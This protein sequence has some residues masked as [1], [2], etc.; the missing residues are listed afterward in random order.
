MANEPQFPPD[1]WLIELGKLSQSWATL[2]HWL[3]M[4]I[5]KLCSFSDGP[6]DPKFV[7]LIAHSSLPQRLDIFAALCHALLDEY[8]HLNGYQDVVKE[9]KAASTER[10]FFAHNMLTVDP[11]TEQVS[12]SVISARGKLRMEHVDVPL[13]RI[14]E[15]RAATFSAIKNFTGSFC[16]QITGPTDF[17]CSA[18]CTPALLACLPHR[19]ACGACLP[20]RLRNCLR[21]IRR[22]CCL[23]TPGY[24]LPAGRGRS[25]H[26]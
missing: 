2:D 16:R 23:R 22:G 10:N 12:A 1:L 13:S 3:N 25:G 9:I 19:P 24:A 8:P 5:E 4:M 17:T 20:R 18:S 15:A 7:I 6:F 21:T 14:V 11:A 26:G